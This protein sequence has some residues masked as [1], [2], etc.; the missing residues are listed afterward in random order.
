MKKIVFSVLSLMM[1]ASASVYAGDIITE[2]QL[3]QKARSLISACYK[4]DAIKSVEKDHSLRG[5]EYEIEF[6]SGAEIDFTYDGYWKKISAAP[7]ESLPDNFVPKD[8]AEY[9]SKEYPGQTVTAIMKHKG[10]YEVELSSDHD[11][12]FDGDYRFVRVD[13]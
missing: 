2:D 11:L 1:L 7:G 8:I 5:T 3:P 13:R 10:G 6:A 4:N 9:L 12:Y